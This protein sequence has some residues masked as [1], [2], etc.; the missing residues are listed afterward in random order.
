[1]PYALELRQRFTAMQNR[2]DLIGFHG[3]TEQV[4]G[5]AEQKRMALKEKVTFFTSDAKTEVAFT[6]GAR[7]VLE[8]AAT[9]DVQAA[10]G[11]VLA[12]MKKNVG[13]SL[14]RSTYDV[15]TADG[16]QLVCRE[17]TMWKALFRRFVDIP[18]FAVQ[19]DVLQGEHV[20]I[21]IDRQMKLRDVYR[22]EVADDTFD[23]RVAGAIAVAQ[24]AFMNR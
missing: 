11:S 8:I 10:D 17:R 1:M 15:V 20:L 6:L 23:W 13:S 12:T 9:Y 3:S 22:V 19:F 24:D 18:L 14:L 16:R 2:Y 7:S 5:Y 4:L 21:T